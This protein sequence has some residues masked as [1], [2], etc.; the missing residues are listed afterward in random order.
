MP[1]QVSDIAV[2]I[3]PARIESVENATLKARYPNA[4]DGSTDPAEGF[5]DAGADAQTA[6]AQ[7]AV[8]QSAERRRFG[9][10]A[11]TLDWPNPGSGL[12]MPRLI[13][14]EQAVDATGLASRIEL[15][16]EAETTGYEVFL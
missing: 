1:A 4:R 8:I 6:L 2:A 14:P 15:D 12:P 7:R 16:L 3:R 5:F 13:D 9:V 11:Q 10:Q